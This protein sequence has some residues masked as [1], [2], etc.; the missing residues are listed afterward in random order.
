[1]KKKNLYK[2]IASILLFFLSGSIIV[3]I[4]K[5]IGINT[6]LFD[7]KD[8]NYLECL[9]ELTLALIVYFL[10]RQY[11]RADYKEIKSGFKK[12]IGLILKYFAL[13][14]AI[15]IASSI[16]TSIIGLIIGVKIG[17][18]ENQ[19]AIVSLTSSAPIIMLI[20]TA[21]LAPIVE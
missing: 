8:L 19:N 13:F 7:A 3:G 17:E 10:Y 6:E 9:I 15:K 18:S 1:M 21:I 4:L 12:Y 2:F 11:F 14:L 16:V 5:G 20:S